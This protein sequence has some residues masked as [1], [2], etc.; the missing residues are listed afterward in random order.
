L[1]GW[2]AVS[3]CDEW[4]TDTEIMA[5]RCD[6]F[7]AHVACSLHG[8]FIILFEQQRTH[9]A[10]DGG[11]VGEDA[12]DLAAP[13][14]L[15]IEPFKRIGNWY[16]DRGAWCSGW[17]VL[18]WR[19]VRPSGARGTGS[20]SVGRPMHIMSRELALV[21]GRPCDPPGCAESADP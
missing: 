7:Q 18:S 17:D 13:L 14:D 20:T 8:P 21:A 5:Q 10:D 19:M 1:A 6:S 15:A 2:T 12:D 3:G 16:E 4:Q 9:Q 11:F